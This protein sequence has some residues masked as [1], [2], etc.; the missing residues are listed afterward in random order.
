MLMSHATPL[1]RGI[2]EYD[3]PT[4]VELWRTPPYLHNGRA[5]TLREV[6]VDHNAADKHGDVSSLQPTEIDDLVAYLLSL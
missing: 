1:D 2:T 6:L 3:V 5:A 4:L